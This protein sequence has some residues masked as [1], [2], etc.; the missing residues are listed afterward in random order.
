MQRIIRHILLGLAI[1]VYLSLS[2]GC[3]DNLTT[4][5]VRQLILT[6]TKYPIKKFGSFEISQ[7]PDHN[8]LIGK[9]NMPMYIKMLAN[10]LITMDIRGIGSGGSEYYDVKITEEGKKYLLKEYKSDDKLLVDVLLGEMI[11]E[12]IIS[13]R[14][15]T[16][17]EG[18]TVKYLDELSRMTPF[19][20]CLIDKTEYERTIRVALHNRKWQIEKK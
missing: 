18:Y 20:A 17:R 14:K 7:S 19:G 2:I 5:K 1:A 11:F 6:E 9:D 8:V 3:S 10:K 13:I 4:D 12:K 16:E 15:D